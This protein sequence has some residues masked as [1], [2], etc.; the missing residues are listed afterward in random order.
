MEAI[1]PANIQRFN[2]M[3]EHAIRIA[4]VTHTKPDGDA[5]GSSAAMYHFLKA[6]GK[7]DVVLILPDRYPSTLSFL[8]EGVN[9]E[10]IL[11]YDSDTSATADEI[12]GR[13]LIICLDFN[14]FSRA[15][16]MNGIL[17]A[18]E[19][20]KVLIDH[21]LNPKTEDFSLV[22]SETEI[23][24]ASEFLY[25]ILMEMPQISHK[26]SNI[27]EKAAEALLTGVTTDTNNFANSTF[28]STLRMTADLIEA[29]VDRDAI[30]DRIN[31]SYQENRLRLLGHVLKD[32][33]VI[34]EDNVAYIVLDRDTLEEYDVKD[35]DTEGFVNMPLGIE[36]VRMS[37][38]A[39]EDSGFMRI[40]I[41]SKKGI[42]ANRLAAARFHGGGHENAAGGRLYM[43]EEIASAEEC[44]GYI[45]EV[46]EKYF[47]L[48]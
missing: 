9:R 31:C 16:E 21:H 29:G 46:T 26:V 6:S 1:N 39:K 42:S 25:H 24:S 18:S 4:I 20:V 44:A 3:V 45:E 11:I 13:D 10:D 23:S 32:R 19:A 38:L 27:P 37:I 34:T 7:D 35:G 17:T 8:T 2:S 33:M 15:G 22:F 47:R 28:P 14:S 40:S 30:V 43:P 36:D 12:A 41:R 48:G 5:I